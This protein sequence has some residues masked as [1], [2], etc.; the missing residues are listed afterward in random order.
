MKV[1]LGG[2]ATTLHNVLRHGR[3]VLIV[4]PARLASVRRQAALRGCRN[5]IVIVTG[6]G[7][8]TPRRANR[9]TVPVMLVRPDG[10]VAVRA[11]P[12]DMRPVIDYLR[13]LFSEPAGQCPGQRHAGD[14]LQPA[15]LAAGHG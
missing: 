2:R 7:T 14:T 6:S 3:H 1:H 10:H 9:G 5:D 11:R 13:D 8:Q 4:P 15:D 12:G